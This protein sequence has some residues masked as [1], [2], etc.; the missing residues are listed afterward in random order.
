MRRQSPIAFAIIATAGCALSL[1][2]ASSTQR[3]C[4]QSA[5]TEPQLKSSKVNQKPAP[6]PEN[7]DFEPET[8]LVMLR[9]DADRDEVAKVLKE[10]NGTVV[11][12]IGEGA[13]TTLVI[14]T[15]PGTLEK[16]EKKLAGTSQFSAI[17]RSF[18]TVSNAIPANPN[19]PYF[20]AQWNLGAMGVPAAWKASTGRR[21]TIAIGDTGCQSSNKEIAGRTYQGLDFT[22][23]KD[24]AP[25]TGNVDSDASTSHGTCVATIA[26]ATTNNKIA[27][28]GL[29]CEAYIYPL[30]IAKKA[31]NGSVELTEQ[32][33]IKAISACG[34]KAIR[35]LNVSYS[36]K[37]AATSMANAELR[38]TL[39]AWLKWYHDQHN[40]LAIFAAGNNGEYDASPRLPYMIMVSCSI[41]NNERWKLS[42]Y[43]NCIWFV[44]PGQA[45]A[46][47]DRNDKIVLT[48]GTSFA[49]PQI[50]ALA[51]MLIAK[52]PNALNTEIEQMMINSCKNI[53]NSK[54]NMEFGYGMPNAT[55]ALVS[56]TREIGD[57]ED[58][59]VAVPPIPSNDPSFGL[60]GAEPDDNDER[61]P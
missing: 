14:Q 53:E 17:Q 19:D 6:P 52:N 22:A 58:N 45:C 48:N 54:W 61:K 36:S 59:N 35:V 5:T 13:M 3:L 37:S 16:T 31:K 32:N 49:A 9:G 26:A 60:P 41:S 15:A 11:S 29:A 25:F 18:T 21:V 56:N 42:N 50:A 8:L 7:L 33:L 28:A 39:H 24:P 43:G 4:A 57:D 10:T 55:K 46:S 51:A 47:T 34:N 38:P 23:G 1:L 44:A 40:G 20:P 12:T 27:T 2:L 30:K